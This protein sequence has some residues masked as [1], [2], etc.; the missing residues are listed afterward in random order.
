ME[1]LEE[2]KDGRTFIDQRT[3]LIIYW[4]PCRSYVENPEGEIHF[5]TETG[6]PFFIRV[7]A[8]EKNFEGRVK[9][10][11]DGGDIVLDITEKYKVDYVSW[12]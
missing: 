1:T 11:D 3:G 8:N 10:D 12:E 6:K 5:R 7:L 4:Q 2:I 9:I